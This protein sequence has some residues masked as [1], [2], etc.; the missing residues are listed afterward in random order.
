MAQQKN[1]NVQVMRARLKDASLS[2]LYLF[3]GEEKMLRNLYIKQVL[4]RY[5]QDPMAEFNI[6]IFDETS[7]IEAVRDCIEALPVM[8]ES[9]LVLLRNTNV[10]KSAPEQTK[11]IW[12]SIFSNP[13]DYAMILFDED[14][15]DKRGTLYKKI[16]AAGLVV[17]FAFRT[18]QQ[19]KKWA[20]DEAAK[21]GLSCEPQALSLLVERS[22]PSMYGIHSELDKLIAYCSGR[23]VISYED[24]AHLVPAPLQDK[25]F[26]MI[27]KIIEKKPELVMNMLS[28]LRQLG[29]SG[30]K[31]LSL[32]GRHF[33]ILIKIQTLE[34]ALSSAELAKAA[35]I[36]PYFLKKYQVQ[37]RGFSPKA[38]AGSAGNLHLLRRKF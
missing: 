26:D 2:G 35:E 8:A 31:I 7:D 12:Q 36:N 9:K 29:E 24:V 34:G 10:L 27:D 13:P 22:G 11:K 18:P 19:L 38:A 33:N 3:T 15:V 25:V 28:D 5:Q 32:I 23:G 14:Q 21:I 4:N 37:V 1:D 6:H 17:D 16:A 20:G 30:A